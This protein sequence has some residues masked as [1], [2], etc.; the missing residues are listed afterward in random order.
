[1][2]FFLLLL[3]WL[4]IRHFFLGFCN[5]F[6]AKPL[7]VL[8]YWCILVCFN[9]EKLRML[10]L[11]QFPALGSLF[12]SL[13]L[14]VGFKY[15]QKR[16]IWVLWPLMERKKPHL[17]G[18]FLLVK[19]VVRLLWSD[20]LKMLFDILIWTRSLYMFSS[21]FFVLVPIKKLPVCLFLTVYFLHPDRNK[22]NDPFSFPSLSVSLEFCS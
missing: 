1:M 16:I 18:L 22:G 8:F 15:C 10:M 5:S 20:Y 9:S 7:V 19:M 14:S 6:G 3:M 17:R 13:L 4:S 21:A 2:H 11:R 12:K